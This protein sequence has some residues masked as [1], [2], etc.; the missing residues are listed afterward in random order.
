M[1]LFLII[2]LFFLSQVSFAQLSDAYFNAVDSLMETTPAI[3]LCKINGKEDLRFFPKRPKN[4]ATTNSSL[5]RRL[6][7]PFSLTQ[8]VISFAT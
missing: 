2:A 4:T 3:E 8:A 6:L 7:M 1:K 5:W